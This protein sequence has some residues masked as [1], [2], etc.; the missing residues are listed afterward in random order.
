MRGSSTSAP[1]T[2]TYADFKTEFET[3]VA[4]GD[5][6]D[7]LAE[8]LEHIKAGR[9]DAVHYCAGMTASPFDA[10]L[11]KYFKDEIAG[12]SW[13]EMQEDGVTGCG[14]RADL[15]SYSYSQCSDYV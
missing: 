6:I 15:A 12:G 8:F 1:A 7:Q 3:A 11:L 9:P 14:G 10:H 13:I 5:I 2:G 4:A